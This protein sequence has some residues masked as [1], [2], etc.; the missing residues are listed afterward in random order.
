MDRDNACLDFLLWIGTFGA[1]CCRRSGKTP[2]IRS[3]FA[4]GSEAKVRE[5]EKKGLVR[6]DTL[7]GGNKKN[8][9]PVIAIT[10]SGMRKLKEEKSFSSAKGRSR[11]TYGI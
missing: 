8:K 7:S 4:K 9:I 5:L 6:Q 1:V 10:E 2:A 11:K 3:D